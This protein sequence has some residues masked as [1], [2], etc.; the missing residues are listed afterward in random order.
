[1]VPF[2]R[3]ASVLAV[4]AVT[5]LGTSAQGSGRNQP[6]WFDLESQLNYKGIKTDTASLIEIARSGA[7]VGTRWMAIEILGLK[8]EHKAKDVLERLLDTSNDELLKETAALA[9]ARLG[10]AK[11]IPALETLMRASTFA[12]RRIFMAARLAEL[13]NPS[14]YT[15]VA[16]AAAGT[17]R[18]LQYLAVGAMFSHQVAKENMSTIF[19]EY[20]WDMGWCDPC[21][22]EPLSAE[23]LRQL[24]VFWLAEAFVPRPPGTVGLRP[25]PVPPRPQNVFMTRLHVRYDAA[26]FPE[27]LVFQETADRSNFQGRYVLRHE[28]KGQDSCEAGERY[29][30]ELPQRHEREAQNLASLT[31][32]DIDQIRRSMNAG[33]PPP[34]ATPPKWW[35]RIWK[36]SG[37]YQQGR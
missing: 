22:A 25:S 33:N 7:D 29:R 34:A 4:L 8:K 9:L 11:G 19:T 35:Q 17:D 23:E 15:Y 37:A 27:D 1:M 13:G 26:H 36:A 5:V 24:G 14:G 2:W 31:G 32:W 30:S 3:F 28:W 21:A 12:H 6:P 10:D 18:Y 20:A 16:Q